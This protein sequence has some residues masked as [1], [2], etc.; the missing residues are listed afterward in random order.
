MDFKPMVLSLILLPVVALNIWLSIQGKEGDGFAVWLL[1]IMILTWA[2][3]IL[4]FAQIFKELKR[5]K[6][7]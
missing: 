7:G 6:N 5:R 3:A 4:V 1:F 2:N